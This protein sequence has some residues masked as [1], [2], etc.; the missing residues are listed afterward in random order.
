MSETNSSAPA[1]EPEQPMTISA[2]PRGGKRNLWLMIV[3]VIVAILLIG[4]AVYVFVL[5]KP[6]ETPP[7]VT[8][9]F[10]VSV[11]PSTLNNMGAGQRTQVRATA[12]YDG[13]AVTSNVSYVWNMTPGAP[14]NLGIF[15]PSRVTATTNFTAN[16][17]GGSGHISCWAKYTVNGTSFH[18][19][20]NVSVTIAPPVLSSINVAPSTL[21]MNPGDSALFTATAVNSVGDPMS[22][23]AFTW[24]V[25][26]MSAGDYTL[27]HNTGTTVNFTAG[28]IGTAW[29]NATATQGTITK[30]GSAEITVTSQVFV[31]SVNYYWYDMFNVPFRPYWDQRAKFYGEERP[32][33]TFPYVF[34]YLLEPLKT[35][36]NLRLN[37]TGRNMTDIN[38]NA[39][40]EFLPYLFSSARGGTAV[41]DW[42][43]QYMTP[44]QLDP[45]PGIKGS[46]D[47]W[48]LEWTGT[49]TMDEQATMSVLGI[50]ASAWADFNNWWS[51]NKGNR[52]NAYNSWLLTEGN[53][54]LD[55][56][57]AYNYSYQPFLFT[58]DAAK[59]GNQVV[60]TYHQISWGMETLMTRWF[61][62]AF[63]STEWYFENFT[64]HATIGPQ[65]TNLDVHTVVIYAAYAY[66]T[67]QVGLEGTPTW[68][69]EGMGQDYIPS[70]PPR[71]MKSDFDAYMV[72]NYTCWTPGSKWYGITDGTPYDYV[73]KAFNLSANETLTFKWPAGDQVFKRDGGSGVI[74]NVTGPMTVTGLEP[75]QSDIAGSNIQIDTV[76]RMV[77]FHGPINMWNWS[78]NDANHPDLD[79]N[80]DRIGMLPHGIPWVEFRLTGT[81]VATS[82]KLENISDPI[83][84]GV[85]DT[86]DV[87]VLDQFNHGFPGYRDM[88]HFTSSDSLAELP[89]DYTFVAGDNGKRSF[90]VVFHTGGDQW[91]RVEQHDDPAMFGEQL[92]ITVIVPPRMDHFDVTG[93]TDPI[94]PGDASNISVAAMDQF[95]APFTTYVGT[96]HF[97][98]SDG[99][100]TLPGDFTFVA[101]DLGAVTIHDAVVMAT[102]GEQWIKVEDLTDPTINGT[103]SGITVLPVRT[104]G[105]FTLTGIDNPALINT[106]QDV[107]VS[108]FDQY[109]DPFPSY[110]GTVNFSAD[111]T[112]MKLPANYTFVLGD[113]GVHTFV[114]GVNFTVAQWYNITVKDRL[115]ATVNGTVMIRAVAS[116]PVINHFVVTGI[117]NMRAGQ[118]SGVTVEAYSQYGLFVDYVGTVHFTTNASAGTYTLPSNYAFTVG[119]AGVH[120]WTNAVSF[121]VKGVYSVTVADTVATSATGTQTGI[122]ISEALAATTLE[123]SGVPATVGNGVPFSL[124]VTI[125]DQDSNVFTGYVGT[126]HFTSSDATAT[127]PADYTFTAGDAG[128]HT[129][130]GL[131]MTT[132]G[133]QTITVTDTVKASLT[134][135]VTATVLAPGGE[136]QINWRLY[137]MFKEPWGQWWTD[138]TWGRYKIED[139]YIITSGAS[140][141][142]FLFMPGYWTGPKASGPHQGVIYAPYR[143]SVDANNVTY[144]NA[145]HPEFMPLR[146]SPVAGSEVTMNVYFQYLYTTWWNNYWINTWGTDPG[147]VGNDWISKANDG[148]YLGTVYNITLNRQ[149]AQAWLNLPQT[150]NPVTWWT[151]NK[152]AY[153]TAWNT[154]ILNEANN[155]LDIYCAYA[156]AYYALATYANLKVN[157]TTGDIEL[158]IAHLSWGYEA[159]MVRWLSE[160]NL[161]P[162]E[163]W[164]EDFTYDVDYSD[165]MVNFTSD[166]AAQWSLK[167][168]KAN[169]T[170]NG[171]A[172]VVEPVFLDYV[173]S[174]NH[175]SRYAPYASLK[176][177]SW[178]AGDNLFSQPVPYDAAPKWFNLSFGEKL[179]IQ[180]PTGTNTIGFKGQATPGGFQD[181]KDLYTG[182]PPGNPHG[183]TAI[184]N[185]GS[186]SLGYFNGGHDLK[187]L[188]NVA[189][190]TL[191]IK[192]PL[193]FDGYKWPSGSL[194]HGVP[195]IEFNV[196][197]VLASAASLGGQAA[198]SDVPA[199]T[200]APPTAAS[201]ITSLMSVACSVLVTVAALGTMAGRRRY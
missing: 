111:K 144:V 176:Y 79:A 152:A 183:F 166:G 113:N 90:T 153:V 20:T 1:G 110:T 99:G 160:T 71:H 199:T 196:T 195:W 106:N 72:W 54:R 63:M 148:Y 93:V 3:A 55:I 7:I 187:P 11:N 108:V 101:G 59:V 42:E 88:V 117:S 114:G 13:H 149:A 51:L 47:G 112:G 197:S 174:G 32:Y 80:W 155:R 22:G 50:D 133:A 33:N 73:P 98:S 190:K 130:A 163:V 147:W 43:L 131:S 177:Q 115:D 137:D 39:K 119:D 96:V 158:T 81:P 100:A 118:T 189:T 65:M 12:M 86:F 37:I 48:I 192:G 179:T 125:R 14:H 173:T 151:A 46:D 102:P 150:S 6:K 52:T 170:A 140:N 139:D 194:F 103:Q 134:D 38:M 17:T 135:T 123:I 40:P 165:H 24:T 83:T 76:N 61:H 178:N 49:T 141:N 159:M 29:L 15:G 75:M 124:T 143:F 169:G 188:Y 181:Y 122:V 185:D 171:A 164:W 60:L 198:G 146:G 28:A 109:G 10:T 26:G 36:T 180:L 84:A 34:D 126:V 56:Y 182:Y 2:A 167:A 168:V 25:G 201:E 128:V 127:L 35:Y 200:S 30:T 116:L 82:F 74:L 172:W 104:A 87:T 77:T 191:T 107:I 44:E 186:M 23:V 162:N 78:R 41:L 97:S 5:N 120:S 9:T 92:N 142:T 62:D 31:R 121:S 136:R 161:C 8:H 175:P 85:T 67:Q 45:Y 89:A 94:I 58:L 16:N 154:W 132:V 19:T 105:S 57:A 64:M 129:F 18:N 184:R 145:S 27:D 70:D 193:N 157:A 69:W 138:P 68:V 53:K 21:D 95:G 66:M 4:T 91:V 156:S